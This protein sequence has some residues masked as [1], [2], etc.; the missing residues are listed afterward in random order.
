MTSPRELGCV[1]EVGSVVR[2]FCGR[3]EI[4]CCQSQT[5]EI[6]FSVKIACEKFVQ[7]REKKSIYSFSLECVKDR[8]VLPTRLSPSKQYNI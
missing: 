5:L 1:A 6:M 3:L 8:E 2:V 4:R 7:K